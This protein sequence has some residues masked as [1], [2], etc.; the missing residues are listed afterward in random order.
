M[1]SHAPPRP[2]MPPASLS[3]YPACT[4]SHPQLPSSGLLTFGVSPFYGLLFSLSWFLDLRTPLL[5][6]WPSCEYLSTPSLPPTLGLCPPPGSPPTLWISVL[7]SLCVFLCFPLPGSPSSGCAFP[8][9]KLRG[10]LPVPPPP[11]PSLALLPSSQKATHLARSPAG[12]VWRAQGQG[13]GGAALC[14]HPEGPQGPRTEGSLLWKPFSSCF[15]GS[16]SVRVSGP[17]KGHSQTSALSR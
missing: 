11:A 7:L 3:P 8:S 14:R 15:P 13:V 6:L 9:T 17:A 1:P 2:C 12:R 10:C 16:L 5:S 4:L